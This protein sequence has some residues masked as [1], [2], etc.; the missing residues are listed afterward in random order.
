MLFVLWLIAHYAATIRPKKLVF[1]L[2]YKYKQI[3]MICF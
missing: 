2:N 3:M 1:Y